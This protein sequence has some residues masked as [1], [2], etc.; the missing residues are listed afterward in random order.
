MHRVQLKMIIGRL[1]IVRKPSIH[2]N[3]VC[4]SVQ[5][6]AAAERARK[7]V[8]TERDELCEELASNSSG[9]WVTC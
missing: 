4:L 5:M 1:I 3:I 7:Q 8:E 6:L 2:D 9:K